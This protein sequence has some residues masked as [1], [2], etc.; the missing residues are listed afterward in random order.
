VLAELKNIGGQGQRR[1]ELE[2]DRLDNEL[3]GK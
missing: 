2:M 1:K 3:M